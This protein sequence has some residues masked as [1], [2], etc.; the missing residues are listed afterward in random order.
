MASKDAYKE[1]YP[2]SYKRALMVKN[3]WENQGIE[4]DQSV[5]ELQIAGSGTGGIGRYDEK[6]ES[7]NQRI[8]IQI[9]PKI[10]NIKLNQ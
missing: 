7:K 2:L 3:L 9:M 6:I 5:C 4:F 10:G 1:N 8:L